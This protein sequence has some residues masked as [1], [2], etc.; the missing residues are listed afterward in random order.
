LHH[1]AGSGTL[2]SIR[3]S[4]IKQEGTDRQTKRQTD[5]TQTETETDRQDTDRDR[6]RDRQP[7]RQTKRR[8]APHPEDGFLLGGAERAAS[9]FFSVSL[10]LLLGSSVSGFLFCA[11]QRVTN[12]TESTAATSSEARRSERMLLCDFSFLLCGPCAEQ[13][14]REPRFSVLV[15]N[16]GKKKS[17]RRRLFRACGRKNP[18]FVPRWAFHSSHHAHRLWQLWGN[19]RQKKISP[20]VTTVISPT[21]VWHVISVVSSRFFLLEPVQ[22]SIKKVRSDKKRKRR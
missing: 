21:N 19:S 12:N 10:S 7:N 15:A 22:L 9:I 13:P 17:K 8:W 18:R 2:F 6:D 11:A 20:T 16:K 1:E 3:S 4:E 5:R 14:P